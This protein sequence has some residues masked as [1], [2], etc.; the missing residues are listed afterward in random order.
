MKWRTALVNVVIF[1]VVATA[2][3]YLVLDRPSVERQAFAAYQAGDY[4]KALPLFKQYVKTP[5]VYNN[6]EQRKR[7]TTIINE[8]EIKLQPSQAA[9]TQGG[10]GGMMD[11]AMAFAMRKPAAS[12][13]RVPHAAYKSGEMLTM[14]IKELGN[15]EFDPNV[16]S[17]VPADV[18][19]L[20]G[21]R[22][23]LN[24]FMIPLT[25]AEKIDKFALVPTLGSCCYGSPPGIQHIVTC[26]LPKGK[27]VDFAIDEIWVEGTLAVDVKR[28]DG[29]TS[30]IFTVKVSGVKLKE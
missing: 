27:G 10:D 15:F 29:F 5:G 21:A 3:G 4:A 23:K 7:V 2:A 25:Q 14:G 20:N 11:Q 18:Q 1:L 13:E 26:E 6:D 19:A 9:G 24:G 28:E 12:A 17:K 30:E 16:D 8:L 22:V